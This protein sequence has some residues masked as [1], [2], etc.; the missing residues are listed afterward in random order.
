MRHPGGQFADRSEF[1]GIEHLLFELFL[2]GDVP[3]NPQHTHDRAIII[4]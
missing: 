2:L 1:F 4:M 3:R